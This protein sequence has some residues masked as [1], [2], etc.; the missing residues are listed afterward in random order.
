MDK[1][2]EII[3]LTETILKN[4]ERQEFPLSNIVFRCARL[5]R[6][7]NNQAA[8]DWFKYEQ[9]GYPESPGGGIEARAFELARFGNRTFVKKEK[10]EQ[11]KE[12]MFPQTVAEIES[13]L[14]AAKEQMKVAHD[15]DIAISSA[16]PEQFVMPHYGNTLE[17]NKL[18][19]TIV[20]K[21][22]K[23]NQIKSAYYNYVLGVYYEMKFKGI[24]EDIF[25]KRKLIVDKALSQHLPGAMEKFV[26]VYENLK[27][28]KPEDWSNALTSCR[29]IIKDIADLLFP[30]S[31]DEIEIEGGEKLKLD[32]EHYIARIKEFVKKNKSSKTFEGLLGSQLEFTAD[33]LDAIY[34]GTNKGT[35][36]NVTQEEAERYV[37]Y[38]YML[39][40]DLLSLYK[41]S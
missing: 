14:D 1:N 19:E 7:T 30:P 33:R 4:I 41:P 12:Y 3:E 6:I 39:L 29:R 22:K 36:A 9:S 13:E 18:K 10:G 17:R 35:H 21:S 23:L 40:G 31:T 25:Q 34:K 28:D 27:S 38:T 24:T 15:H 11:S 20:E 8:I 37:M 32:D 5:A 16:N 2:K 26:V